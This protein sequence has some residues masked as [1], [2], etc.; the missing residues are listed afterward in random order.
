MGPRK[1]E[2]R[3]GEEFAVDIASGRQVS[4]F[5]SSDT[6]SALENVNTVKRQGSAGEPRASPRPA[7]E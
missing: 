1:D 7:Q 3:E 5:S 2:R 4:S 6:F